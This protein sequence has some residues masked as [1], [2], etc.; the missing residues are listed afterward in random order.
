MTQVGIRE[1]KTHASEL[2]RRV[3]DDGETIEITS[4]GRAMA[5]L[6]PLGNARAQSPEEQAT[7]WAEWRELAERIGA[8]WPHDV[9][10]VEAVREQRR[11]LCSSL[12]PAP[13]S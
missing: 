8:A 4:R 6:V 1:L 2:I 11:D 10:A 3:H 13:P 7:F 9:S 5:R 12:T